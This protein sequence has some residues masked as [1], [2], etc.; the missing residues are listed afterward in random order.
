MCIIPSENGEDFNIDDY[1]GK[2]TWIDELFFYNPFKHIWFKSDFDSKNYGFWKYA[3]NEN[4][5][6][7]CDRKHECIIYMI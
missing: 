2:T 7:L 3:S 5:S 1:K 6:Y 4:C